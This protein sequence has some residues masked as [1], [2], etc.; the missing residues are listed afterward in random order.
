MLLFAGLLVKTKALASIQRPKARF[1]YVQMCVFLVLCVWVCI[2]ILCVCIVLWS[3]YC[4]L[5]PC[6]LSLARCC[7]KFCKSRVTPPLLPSALPYRCHSQQFPTG[8]YAPCCC[9]LSLFGCPLSHS[10][11]LSLTP[12]LIPFGI[13]KKCVAT[14]CRQCVHTQ[15]NAHTY[16]FSCCHRFSYVWACIN[17]LVYLVMYTYVCMCLCMQQQRAA[18][19]NWFRCVQYTR[20]DYRPKIT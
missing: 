10:L 3:L 9:S 11:S 4:A 5:W 15:T 14:A 12:P 7:W 16:F 17:M 18:C 6:T 8:N 19:L 13:S 1:S 20:R 2:C